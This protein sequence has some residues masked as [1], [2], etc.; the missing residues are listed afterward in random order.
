VFAKA[1]SRRSVI[2]GLIVTAAAGVAAYFDF[3]DR[4]GT[5][6]DAPFVNVMEYGAVGN[7]TTDDSGAVQSAYNQLVANGGGTL[8][9]PP[10]RTYY[11]N[12]AFNPAALK[13]TRD[14]ART[15][16]KTTITGAG[17]TIK[18]S[19]A[20][21]RFIDFNKVADYDLF[22]HLEVRDLT[23][24]ADDVQGP[25]H[26][27]IGCYQN[28]TFQQRLN[29]ESITV[30]NIKTINVFSD[31]SADRP[32]HE[33]LNVDLT[34]W[35]QSPG[36]TTQTHVF[37]F[38]VEDCEF[39][40][41][42]F[43][44]AVVPQNVSDGANIA[45]NVFLDRIIVRR[46]KHDTLVK[47]VRPS[48]SA[49]VQLGQ[50]G[51]GGTFLVEDCRSYNSFDVGVELDSP[52]F[53][54][55]T[56]CTVVDAKMNSFLG[57]NLF[58]T[59]V[60]AESQQIIFDSCHVGSTVTPGSIGY[61]FGNSATSPAKIGH[62]IITNCSWLSTN[63]HFDGL[64]AVYVPG[65]IATLTIDNLSVTYTGIKQ[66]TSAALF[67]TPIDIQ[68]LSSCAVRLRNIKFSLAGT[69]TIS[70][71]GSI[72][73]QMLLISPANA[74]NIYFDV[75]SITVV[76]NVTG[77]VAGSTNMVTL[78]GLGIGATSVMQGIVRGL[79]VVQFTGDSAPVG[80]LVAGTA[81]FK[82]QPFIRIEDTDWSRAPRGGTKYSIDATQT[83][84][85]IAEN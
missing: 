43:G 63:A 5:T 3:R 70:G 56:D 72:R 15:R 62:G 23:I 79:K 45:C 40:G 64:N 7:G 42:N 48:S 65:D 58:Q 47:P 12:N 22:R 4:T 20:T 6:S 26:V 36:E 84:F 50:G 17:A 39:S 29:F 16:R 24:D 66:S 76:S 34:S 69:T 78:G 54:R 27:V 41:G 37:D 25:H 83:A 68:P 52:T 74:G 61:Q 35:H 51:F 38:L 33:R 77:G 46:I 21:P 82:I 10:E 49:G 2:G 31:N 32:P 44:V 14:N 11:M 28:G 8:V 59:P 19:A 73:T 81:N 71:G 60:N 85:V 1:V 75:S 80:F 18:L 30:R 55:V 53:A 13:V 57:G 67:A 9:F